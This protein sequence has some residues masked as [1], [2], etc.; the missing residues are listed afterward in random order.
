V[1][2]TAAQR[3]LLAL[4]VVPGIGPRLLA[5]LLTRFGTAAAVREAA[6]SELTAIPHLHQN[7]A[8]RLQES[9][10]RNAV[11]E[12]LVLMEKHGVHL[13]T[14]D[15]PAYPVNLAKIDVPP[16]LL[17]VR[18]KLVPEDAQAVAVVGSRACTSYGRRSAERMG[19]ALARAGVTVVSGLARGIDGMAHRGALS[20]KGRT[21]A[22]LAGGLAKIYPPEHADLA[23]EIVASG[24]ALVTESAMRMEP[25]ADLFP[26][27]NRIISG[28]AR[29]V[30]L[31]E[32]AEKSGAL[33]TARRAAEQG[34][35][36]F[37]VP[38][39][40]DSPASAGALE[41]L[42]QGAKLVRHAGDVLEDLDGIAPLVA[43]EAVAA[44]PAPP[45]LDGPQQAIWDALTEPRTIDELC[46]H[47][48]KPIGELTGMLMSLE[49]KRV[50]RRLP[51][52]MYERW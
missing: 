30:V 6:L 1:D 22:V 51:G 33:I 18:G 13:L 47:L 5:A 16:R 41:L 24:G 40:A 4:H 38:G 49:M 35:E 9:L 28:L 27:R 14:L 50:V 15:T 8:L 17:F 21:I 42:R 7:V 37:A 19:A 20:V 12:E 43:L 23:E 46:R 2:L 10:R 36:V 44:A 26:P 52:N 29:G 31:V 39:N 11:D 25:M 45:K 3:D 34:R 32:A 48:G